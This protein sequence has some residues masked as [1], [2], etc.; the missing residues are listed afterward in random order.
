MLLKR[1]VSRLLALIM[2]EILTEIS[3]RGEFFCPPLASR[4]VGGSDAP[5]M[6]SRQSQ[7]WT[8]SLSWRSGSG[9]L[10]GFPARHVLQFTGAFVVCSVGWINAAVNIQHT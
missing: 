2:C 8:C 10:L 6:L 9:A 4:R 7:A 5:R 1:N 3:L